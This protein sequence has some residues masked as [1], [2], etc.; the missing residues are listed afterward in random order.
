MSRIEFTVKSLLL[1]DLLAAMTFWNNE[2]E[3]HNRH[4]VLRIEQDDKGYFV[5]HAQMDARPD[6]Q[7][8][9]R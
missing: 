7:E 1:D 8:N 9:Y 6:L 3:W 5:L 4:P 2:Y